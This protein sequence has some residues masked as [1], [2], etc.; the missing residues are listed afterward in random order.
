M[1]GLTA[2]D[3][4]K[5]D[6]YLTR[7]DWVRILRD[8]RNRLEASSMYVV[9]DAILQSLLI[10]AEYGKTLR[11]GLIMELNSCTPDE[12]EVMRAALID[13]RRNG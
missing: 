6:D 7:R 8:A 5:M 11:K 9:L 12:L 1:V 13:E 3:L 10:D 4:A 2:D